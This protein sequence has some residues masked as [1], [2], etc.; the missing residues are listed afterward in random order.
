MQA[1]SRFWLVALCA[2]FPLS[3]Q[4]ESR[5]PLLSEVLEIMAREYV[6][7]LRLEPNALEARIRTGVEAKCSSGCDSDQSERAI[8]SSLNSV[9][10]V[11]LKLLP[12]AIR[13]GDDPGE[14]GE[15]GHAARFGIRT[16]S[17]KDR[18]LVSSVQADSSAA[19]AN[20]EFGDRIVRVN[21][22]ESPDAMTLVL[23]RAEVERKAVT[24]TLLN[25]QGQRRTV[26]LAPISRPWNASL[27]LRDDGIAVLRLPS[28]SASNEDDSAV[29]RL[30]R[31]AMQ[32]GARA[33]ILDLRDTQGG[34]PFATANAAGAFLEQVAITLVSKAGV[35]WNYTFQNGDARLERSDQ[36]T[37][38]ETDRL[39]PPAL[40]SGPLVV[41]VSKRTVSAGEN[42]ALLLQRT[43]RALVIGEVTAGGAGVG[44]NLFKLSSNANLLLATHLHLSPDGRR[45][46]IRITP[47]QLEATDLEA[48]SR[49]QDNVLD[50]A[51][52]LLQLK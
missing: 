36:P 9:G 3:I 18:L 7:P 50:A 34:T 39:E 24:V 42:L 47:D 44:A 31:Q 11:H 1:R 16:V 52:K 26:S 12:A 5:T 28:V 49:G 14:V 43:G 45:Y 51:S 17:T 15:G 19:S 40:W 38:P 8:A 10:D 27:E 32:S 2:L 22:D 37:T 4:A 25:Q 21:N 46:P 20:L 23:A 33:M 29:H 30:V 13:P 41:L 6:N 35:R 48:L